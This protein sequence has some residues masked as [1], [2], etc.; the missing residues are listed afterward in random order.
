MTPR[1]TTTDSRRSAFTL[2]E[3]LVAI[4]I[5]G[6]VTSLVWTGFSQTSRNKR[7]VEEQVDRYHV[8]QL[9][10]ER[11]ARELSMAYVS[12]QQNPSPALRTVVTG[13]VGTDRVRA[14]R[15]DFT[16]FSHQRLYRD[17]NESDQ[18]EIS[19]FVTR[20]PKDR[21]RRVLARREQNRIDD[22]PTEGGVVQVMVEDVESFTL[23]YYDPASGE[24]LQTWDSTQ[25][26][27]QPNRLPLQV[28]IL[29]EVPDLRKPRETRTFGTRAVIPMTWAL[30][31]A[32]YNP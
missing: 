20:D 29:L 3:A 12:A 28:K 19:Y 4:T 6:L 7:R 17:A 10:L 18:N 30:N 16:S 8:I 27:M 15:I 13:F 9:V 5:L 2:V 11:M 26:A 31:H 32:T 25:P 14:D 22:D 23:E 24:W 21:S 1:P